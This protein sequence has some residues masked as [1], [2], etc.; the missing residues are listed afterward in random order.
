MA[1]MPCSRA[2]SM[3][4]LLQQASLS[5]E[6]LNSPQFGAFRQSEEESTTSTCQWRL[7]TRLLWGG[8]S[9]L[10]I[11]GVWSHT[12]LWGGC[13]KLPNDA[14]CCWCTFEGE[15]GGHQYH[16]EQLWD[17]PWPHHRGGLFALQGGRK[18]TT[19][20]L[21][22]WALEG[23]AGGICDHYFLLSVVELTKYTQVESYEVGHMENLRK[24]GAYV[25]VS[26]ISSLFYFI[27]IL[28][29][30]M[31]KFKSKWRSFCGKMYIFSYIENIENK[32]P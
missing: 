9:H 3:Y 32:N 27:L 11:Q 24:Q 5:I 22:L 25:L 15:S 1:F 16:I 26:R 18:G 14:A 6:I 21:K 28:T 10:G 4:K 13:I 20:A 19:F 23:L 8:S 31:C 2:Q 29:C 7:T 12:S 17:T 30:Y